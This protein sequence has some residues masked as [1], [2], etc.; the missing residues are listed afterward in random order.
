MSLL[1]PARR[2]TAQAPSAYL[3]RG[4]GSYQALEFDSAAGWLRR[5]LTPPLVQELPVADQLR[6]LSY[7]GATERFRG[8]ADSAAAAF[9]RMLRLD[10]QARPDPLV[11]P[12]EVTTLFDQ[13][14]AAYPVVALEAAPDAEIDAAH[15]TYPLILHSSTPH[16]VTLTLDRADGRAADTLYAGRVGDTLAV[17]W[18]GRDR[19]GAPISGGRYWITATSEVEGSHSCAVR[20]PVEIATAPLDTL[21]TPLGPAAA[22]PERAGPGDG[23]AAFAKGGL[24]A[25]AAL[26]L[27]L[28]SRDAAPGNSRIVAGVLGAGGLLGFILYR[29]GQVIPANVAA[30]ATERARWE[31]QVAA[32]SA[33]NAERRRT[34]PLRL[35]ASAPVMVGC[36]AP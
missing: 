13:V 31:H 9:Q 17:A 30:N 26:A 33:L 2:V 32:T 3:A 12:P 36:A 10:P 34:V 18:N 28:V 16:E 4:I 21:P 15:P 8:R 22:R 1:A 7:L 27:T 20:L 35:H 25:G 6:G 11:F 5:A 14:R 24:L 29:P 23:P 19:S